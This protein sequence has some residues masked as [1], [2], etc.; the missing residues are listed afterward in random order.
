[1]LT[2]HSFAFSLFKIIEKYVADVIDPKISFTPTVTLQ[3][4]W[5]FREKLYKLG[6][7]MYLLRVNAA[8][9]IALTIWILW[10]VDS[11]Q[12]SEQ[13]NGVMHTIFLTYPAFTNYFEFEIQHKNIYAKIFDSKVFAL[14]N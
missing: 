10:G 11:L 6:A 1:M 5:Q 3:K 8:I 9:C 12:G 2:Y 4:D 14:D 13:Y 7:F